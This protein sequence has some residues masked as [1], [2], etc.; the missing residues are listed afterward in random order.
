M[1]SHYA[2][3]MQSTQHPKQE[4]TVSFSQKHVMRAGGVELPVS[5]GLTGQTGLDGGR[6]WIKPGPTYLGENVRWL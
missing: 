4:H 5:W 6:L 1:V 2:D 3:A